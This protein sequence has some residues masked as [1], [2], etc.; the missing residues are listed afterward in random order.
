MA[1]SGR[2]PGP[3]A[4]QTRSPTSQG[5]DLSRYN[6]SIEDAPSAVAVIGAIAALTGVRRRRI[7]ARASAG[8]TELRVPCAFGASLCR[9]LCGPSVAG[10][11]IGGRYGRKA[12]MP[13]PPRA[14][15]RETTD[16]NTT[17]SQPDSRQ[18]VIW[19]FRKP[20]RDGRQL[21]GAGRETLR[22]TLK[23]RGQTRLR[24]AE[25]LG[26]C[27]GR[28]E[29]GPGRFGLRRFAENPAEWAINAESHIALI[30]VHQKPRRR[31][32]MAWFC[33][34]AI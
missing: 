1:L 29:A 22:I 6:N 23:S 30:Y 26:A 8:R 13:T 15:W 20:R 3:A 27:A 34:L 9:A 21:R 12:F 2:A 11:V 31:C 16:T 28:R 5:R 17:S 32:P 25:L 33:R 7:A 24:N 10:I 18:P 14:F 19:A 4:E